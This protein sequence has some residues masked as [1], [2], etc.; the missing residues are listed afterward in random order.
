MNA[1]FWWVLE[2]T[3]VIVLL[4]PLVAAVCRLFRNR[5]AVQH[6]LWVV[7]LFKFIMPPV[8]SWPWSVA[9]LWPTLRPAALARLDSAPDELRYS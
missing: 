7:L 8:W 1:I 4:I 9:Q 6:V 3:I 5:P 2:N